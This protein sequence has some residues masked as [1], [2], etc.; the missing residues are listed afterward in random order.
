MRDNIVF[1]NGEVLL[2]EA[3]KYAL[4][5]YNETGVT[6]STKKDSPQNEKSEYKQ[7][8]IRSDGFVIYN[9]VTKIESFGL[10][11]YIKGK[12]AYKEASR[13]S[14]LIE[15]SLQGTPEQTIKL[16]NLKHLSVL[17]STPI[18]KNELEEQRYL[19][20][21]ATILGSQLTI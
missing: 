20:I 6:V 18:E 15:A 11:I 4:N 13:I 3:I 8:V 9:R 5:Y 10:N 19:R 7:I 21:E 16:K 17:N 12:N 14:S 2:I 1:E